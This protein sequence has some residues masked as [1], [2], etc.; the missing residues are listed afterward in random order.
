MAFLLVS[1]LFELEYDRHHYNFLLSCSLAFYKCMHSLGELECVE[2]Y[3]GR[4]N[5][6][7]TVAIAT[8]CMSRC[9][10]A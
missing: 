9:F 5:A 8:G 2:N 6:T 7:K 4:C 1:L 3:N 10:A